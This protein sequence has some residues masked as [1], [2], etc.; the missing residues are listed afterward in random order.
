MGTEQKSDNRFLSFVCVFR[1][2]IKYVILLF[3]SEDILLI[4][5]T[6]KKIE[7]S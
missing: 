3:H 4:V 2:E 6:F 1:N 7:K 5:D